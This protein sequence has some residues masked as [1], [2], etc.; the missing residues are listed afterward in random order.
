M[1]KALPI[2]VFSI[3]SIF[4]LES[5]ENRNFIFS[6]ESVFENGTWNEAD[7]VTFEVDVLDTMKLYNLGLIVE[8]SKNYPAQNIYLKIN[9]TFPDR[10]YFTQ[11][12]NID[13]ANQAGK[14]FGDCSGDICEVEAFIQQG[15]Y[16]N[17]QGK[18]QFTIKQFTR[19]VD[20]KN[21]NRLQ[22]FVEDMQQTR[23][24]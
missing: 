19:D 22:F 24:Q 6:D 17:Q 2:I 4:I 5:C 10:Q 23:Q 20:L 8:H 1:S 21:I 18:Y 7:S 14:W 15:A 12:V 9:T 11:R 13:F 16:F 3:I